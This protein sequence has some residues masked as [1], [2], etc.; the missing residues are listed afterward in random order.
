MLW[1]TTYRGCVTS[2]SVNIGSAVLLRSC[3]LLSSTPHVF[4][5]SSDGRF[6][7]TLGAP[8]LA[9]AP[10][11]HAMRKTIGGEQQRHALYAL[12]KHHTARNN[13]KSLSPGFVQRR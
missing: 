10:F 11:H 13:P 1:T 7:R 4:E 9:C 2:D 5:R 12:N 3:L 8:T 6:R